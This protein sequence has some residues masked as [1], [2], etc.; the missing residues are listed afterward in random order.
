MLSIFQPNTLLTAL[1]PTQEFEFPSD[2]ALLSRRLREAF[3]V[4]SA[5]RMVMAP[6]GAQLPPEMARAVLLAGEE[7]ALELAPARVAL[8]LAQ[9]LRAGLPLQLAD[10]GGAAV[11]AIFEKHRSLLES[12]HAWLADNANFHA[13]RVGVLAQFF[14][15]TRSSA[16]SKIAQYFLHPRA[17][18]GQAPLEIDVSVLARL[19]LDS[20]TLVNRWLRA[21]PLR[22]L[23][24]R[25]LDF[26][27]QI[28]IDINTL[29]EDTRVRGGVELAQHLAAV[30]RHIARDLPLFHDADFLV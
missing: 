8:R 26:A 14:C 23:D 16:N 6:D 27:A 19:A 18:Q 12:L 7:W 28:E 9:P 1:W 24:A 4:F 3:P 17:L 5:E 30:E 13:Y 2:A 25:H 21:R 15:E 22:T 29:P 20:G 11:G 10:D